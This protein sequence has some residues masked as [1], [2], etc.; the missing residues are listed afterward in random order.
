MAG[1]RPRT[2][3]PGTLIK[4]RRYVNAIFPNKDEVIPT[5]EGLSLYLGT[6]RETVYAWAKEEDKKEFSDTVKVLLSKQGL[7]L[8][9]GGLNGAFNAT[10]A[11]LLLSSNHGMR[12][13]TD[14]TTDDK[15]LPAPTTN[16]LSRVYGNDKA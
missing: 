1:G 16:I 15:P 3:G 14:L 5:V 8:Q 13:R 9:R 7:G 12:E 10:I 4:A 11:K 2:Y 6:S